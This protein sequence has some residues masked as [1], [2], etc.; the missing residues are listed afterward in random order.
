[1][2]F[3]GNH[4]LL[5]ERPAFNIPPVVTFFVAV[6]IVI[7]II[8][9][10]LLSDETDATLLLYFAFNPARYGGNEGIGLVWPGGQEADIWSL[11]THALLHYSTAHLLV[12]CFSLLIFGGFIARLFSRIGFFLFCSVISVGS[13]LF[14]LLFHWGEVSLLLG[15]SGFISGLMGA[16]VRFFLWDYSGSLL[17]S[18]QAFL[19]RKSMLIFAI[20]YIFFNI[21]NGLGFAFDPFPGIAP[22]R[23]AWEAHLGG[24]AMGFFFFPLFFRKRFS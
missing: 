15:A 1:M 12:N 8:R 2:S 7:H 13:A 4:L 20:F 23:V 5:S 9:R 22:D 14:Y 16:T 3:P 18:S 10:T 11:G 19:F 17:S 21:L 24:F 6:L